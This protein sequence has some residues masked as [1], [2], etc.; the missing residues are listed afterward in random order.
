MKEEEVI[1]FKKEAMYFK[2]K[3]NLLGML[4][5]KPGAEVIKQ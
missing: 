2:T 3:L 4:P 1:Y 5:S